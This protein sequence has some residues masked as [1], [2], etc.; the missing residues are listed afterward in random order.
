M[1]KERLTGGLTRCN[2]PSKT[3][4]ADRGVSKDLLTATLPLFKKLSTDA[5]I[6]V[7]CGGFVERAPITREMAEKLCREDVIGEVVR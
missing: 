4:R 7:V 6:W 1:E 5:R 3:G 2:R